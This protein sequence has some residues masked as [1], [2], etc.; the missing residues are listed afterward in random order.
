M[1]SVY[2][3]IY[4]G[5]KCLNRIPNEYKKIILNN[6]TFFEYGLQGPDIFNNDSLTKN[7]NYQSFSLHNRSIINTLINS[8]KE[9]SNIKNRDKTLSY[10]FGYISHFLLDSYCF[11]YLEKASKEFNKSRSYLESN[12]ER[13]LLIKNFKNLK[14]IK[15]NKRYKKSREIKRIIYEQIIH[16]SKVINNSIDNFINFNTLIYT[17]NKYLNEGFKKYLHLSKKEQYEDRIIPYQLDKNVLASCVRCDK[18]LEIATFH[19]SE[20]VINYM[21]FLVNDKEL[22]SYY[23]N[24]IW[25]IS[26]NEIPVLDIN[27]ELKYTLSS[28]KR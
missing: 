20:L 10:M 22:N 27:D 7:D 13:Y 24:K 3:H 8:K 28:L 1:P 21:D 4:F 19:Y 14:D 6:K 26:D 17:D 18:Y 23:K 15:I 2:A 16:D 11:E 5:Q 25:Y 12:F 9:M